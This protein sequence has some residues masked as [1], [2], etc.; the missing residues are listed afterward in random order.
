MNTFNSIT[1]IESSRFLLN[2]MVSFD[3]ILGELLYNDET[4]KL[5]YIESKILLLLIN[6]A[7]GIVSRERIIEYA[8]CGRVVTDSSL[9]KSMS[10]LRRALKLCDIPDDEIIT[11]PRVG[12]RLTSQT[13]DLDCNLNQDAPPSI[14]PSL[15]MTNIS[16]SKK[17]GKIFLFIKS[18]KNITEFRFLIKYIFILSGMILI[19]ASS[20]N[21][22]ESIVY[23]EGGTFIADGYERIYLKTSGKTYIIIKSDSLPLNDFIESLIVLSPSETLVFIDNEYGVYNISYFFKGKPLSFTFS[24][25]NKDFAAVEIKSMLL[26]LGGICAI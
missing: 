14:R 13:V 9:A 21:F 10:N 2:E 3:A 7:G 4:I 12:Y 8:W 23:D 6:H 19:A 26:D 5:T 11:I 25:K 15:N 22:Y 1:N 20:F 24:E 16:L 17:L 18:K